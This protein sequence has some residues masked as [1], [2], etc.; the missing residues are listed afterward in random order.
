LSFVSLA[1]GLQHYK[2]YLFHY[3][4]A[5]QERVLAAKAAMVALM[6]LLER[7]GKEVDL[8]ASLAR[9]LDLL[10]RAGRG[11]LLLEV[12][13]METMATTATVIV[14]LMELLVRVEREVDLRASLAR[15]LD[16]LERAGR[17]HRLLEEAM[18]TD[19]PAPMTIMVLVPLE[20]Q[21]KVLPV[22]LASLERVLPFHLASQAKDLHLVGMPMDMMDIQGG[23]F[24]QH[25]KSF[26]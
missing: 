10:E 17:D 25:S 24:E 8:R 2:Q 21:E 15:A 11:H 5:N 20:S 9:A 19:I 23:T 18:V 14:A 7:V 4:Q 13:P 22:R 12:L 26:S 16:L 6:D 1:P 3:L